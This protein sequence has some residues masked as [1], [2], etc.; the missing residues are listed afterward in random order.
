M[1]SPAVVEILVAGYAVPDNE[2]DSVSNQLS[3]QRS[4]GSG[5]LVDPAGYIMTN[6]H[7]IQGAVTIQVLAGNGSAGSRFQ[8]TRTFDARVLGIDHDS[9]RG[10]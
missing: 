8:K 10:F 4:S 1:F 2:N 7:V 6:A 3:R 9:D 5:V